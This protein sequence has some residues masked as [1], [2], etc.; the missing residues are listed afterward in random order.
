M[1]QYKNTIFIT[2]FPEGKDKDSE[3]EK[4]LKKKVMA[5]IFQN[6]VKDINQQIQEAK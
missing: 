1:E 5:E 3:T 6:L 4:V 2:R